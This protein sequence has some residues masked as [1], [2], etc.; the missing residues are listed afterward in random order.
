MEK[1]LA[2][3][4]KEILEGMGKSPI[5]ETTPQHQSPTMRSQDLPETILNEEKSRTPT[6]KR[7]SNRVMINERAKKESEK[8]KNQ[9]E[10]K[11]KR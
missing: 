3:D 10:R 1:S 5:P 7:Q 2:E 4:R 9:S 11:R 6:P 8:K